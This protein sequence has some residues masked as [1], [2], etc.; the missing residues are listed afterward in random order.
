MPYMLVGLT[1]GALVGVLFGGT[2]EITI[3]GTALGAG[4]AGALAFRAIVR[5][6][7]QS[8]TSDALS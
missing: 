5:P 4:L 6:R 1:A 3:F 7:S 2:R 8:E